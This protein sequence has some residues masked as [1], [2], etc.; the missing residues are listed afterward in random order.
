MAMDF[1]VSHPRE[2]SACSTNY[3]SA[4]YAIS[5]VPDVSAVFY[6]VS[7]VNF[8]QLLL[9]LPINQ[10]DIIFLLLPLKILIFLLFFS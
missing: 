5:V 10:L 8:E 2:Q 7:A 1:S 4:V 6:V 9:L 3:F